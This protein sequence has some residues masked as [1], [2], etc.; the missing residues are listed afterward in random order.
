[1]CQ[2]RSPHS[3][4]SKT[5]SKLPDGSRLFIIS[6]LLVLGLFVWP[7]NIEAAV[8]YITEEGEGNGK[9]FR[10]AV[11]NALADAISRVNGITVGTEALQKFSELT[12]IRNDESSVATTESTTRFIQTQ[13]AGIVKSYRILQKEVATDGVSKIVLSAEIWR[14]ENSQIKRI[15]LAVLPFS[16]E[17]AHFT[18]F[19][20]RPEAGAIGRRLHSKVVNELVICRKFAILDREFDSD[21]EAALKRLASSKLRIEERARLGQEIGVDYILVG[22]IETLEAIEKTLVVGT[23]ARQLKVTQARFSAPYRIVDIA[24]GQTVLAQTANDEVQ[25]PVI[26]KPPE[27]DAIMGDLLTSASKR[28]AS[29]ILQTIYP[30]KVIEIEPEIVLNMGGESLSEGQRLAVFNLGKR[31][32]DPY[33]AEFLGYAEIPACIL[34]ITRVSPKVAYGLVRESRAKVKIGAICRPETH[35]KDPAAENDAAASPQKI[36]N[37]LDA[38]FK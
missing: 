20:A 9:D 2:V 25:I 21:R 27:I 8:V 13:T 11:V 10:E 37:A 23:S 30:I 29:R 34:E 36:K 3:S 5:T 4:M 26:N 19:G 14:Y 28:I 16:A 12:S 33:T 7:C 17:E 6:L 18:V 24:S 31:L 32:K 38:L 1:M 35:G 22:R 15:R